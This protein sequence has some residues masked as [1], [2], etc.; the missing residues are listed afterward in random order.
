MKNGRLF[1]NSRFGDYTGAEHHRGGNINNY[2]A[3]PLLEGIKLEFPNAEVTHVVGATGLGGGHACGGRDGFETI[4]RHHFKPPPGLVSASAATKGGLLG[5]Y[6]ENQDLR[7]PPNHN[8]TD[9]APSFHW[10]L[11][12]PIC[13]I[14]D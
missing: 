12:T 9:Y 6:W 1:C 11:P 4:F 2:N 5:E 7:G 3:V 13:N 14:I 8:R 10:Y